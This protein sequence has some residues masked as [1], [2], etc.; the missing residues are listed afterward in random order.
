MAKLCARCG[1]TKADHPK[2]VILWPRPCD[3]FVEA[4]QTLGEEAQAQ[5][6]REAYEEW[7]SRG[8][9]VTILDGDK[10]LQGWGFVAG[11]AAGVQYG[12]ELRGC[13]QERE[14]E[15]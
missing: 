6:A 13:C 9:L 4:K 11:F 1:R 7:K 10:R 14:R 2:G 12:L 5:A 15:R 8:P 3:G